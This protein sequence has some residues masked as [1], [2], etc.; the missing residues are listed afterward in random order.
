MDGVSSTSAEETISTELVVNMVHFKPFRRWRWWFFSFGVGGELAGS[1]SSSASKVAHTMGTAPPCG[2]YKELEVFSIITQFPRECL[3]CNSKPELDAVKKKRSGAVAPWKQ[4]FSVSRQA[5]TDI[6]KRRKGW[7]DKCAEDAKRAAALKPLLEKQGRPFQFME[8]AFK[9]MASHSKTED[10][11]S[12]DW[13]SPVVLSGFQHEDLPADLAEH[14]STFRDATWKKHLHHC[15]NNPPKRGIDQL[16]TAE[17]TSFKD[18]LKPVLPGLMMDAQASLDS[19]DSESFAPGIFVVNQQSPTW[20]WE[21]RFS[22]ALRLTLGEGTRKVAIVNAAQLRQFMKSDT[23]AEDSKTTP[24]LVRNYWRSKLASDTA[25]L[26]SYTDAGNLGVVATVGHGDLLFLPSGTLFAELSGNKT[27]FG[28]KIGVAPVLAANV[29]ALNNTSTLIK[30]SGG[31]D[32]EVQF[33]SGL[34][35]CLV[36][37]SVGVIR[38]SRRPL[39]LDR[40]LWPSRGWW[41]L[42]GSPSGLHVLHGPIRFPIRSGFL[43]RRRPQAAG[44]RP[45]GRRQGREGPP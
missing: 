24:N 30:V 28:F 16:S 11:Q 20:A 45:E 31:N 10:M 38:R 40:P 41:P 39:H 35:V 43:A 26:R 1:S 34:V 6:E 12:I 8:E 5:K 3:A 22:A 2:M 42:T 17:A 23:G 33:L 7:A 27:V 25:K 21:P 32:T 36:V 4:L 18:F 44:G 15:G 29:D 19:M 13:S 14:L 9:P 37:L